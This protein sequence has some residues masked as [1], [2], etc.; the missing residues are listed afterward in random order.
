MFQFLNAAEAIEQLAR[1]NVETR[2][3]DNECM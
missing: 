3:T 1:Q 2:M